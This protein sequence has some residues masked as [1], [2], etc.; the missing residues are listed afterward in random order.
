MMEQLPIIEDPN[1]GMLWRCTTCNNY[2]NI[3]EYKEIINNQEIYYDICFTCRN[4]EYIA[5]SLID[6]LELPIRH[7]IQVAPFRYHPSKGYQIALSQRIN[8]KKVFYGDFQG[9]GG[10]GDLDENGKPC[11]SEEITAI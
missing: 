1:Y 8:P 10:K 2:C 9:M 6:H 7:I 5:Q 11:E 4:L 3:M